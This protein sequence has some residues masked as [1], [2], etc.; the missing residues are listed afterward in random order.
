M[1]EPI[2]LS[3]M[4]EKTLKK[5]IE[6][7]K[8]NFRAFRDVVSKILDDVKRNGDRAL[9]KYTRIYDGVKI[10]IRQLK[11]SESEV[12]EAYRKTPKTLIKAIEKASKNLREIHEKQLPKNRILKNSG[13]VYVKQVFKPINSVGLYVPC[14][15][16][17]YPST[18]LMLGIPAKIA[19]VKRLVACTPPTKT[20]K[21]NPAILVAL[22]MVGVD[23]VY[24]V[25]G[26]QA[27][28]ALA[29]GTQTI[30]RVDKIV[31]PGNIYVTTAKMMVYGEVGIDF[32]AGPS[33][34]LVFAD[35]TANPTLVFLDMVSQAEHDNLSVPILV[36]TSEKLALKVKEKILEFLSKK[37]EKKTAKEALRKNSA[38]VLVKDE[39]EAANFINKFAPEHL[40]VFA[41]NPEK[42]ISLIYNAGLISVGKYTPVAVADYAIGVSHVLPTSRTASFHSGLTVYDFLK[43]IYIQQLTKNGLKRLK[44]IVEAFAMV[45]GLNWHAES[46]RRRFVGRLKK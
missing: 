9:I 45:E 29:Y 32:P 38:I 2:R 25:G 37:S 13:G 41:K 46:V 3:E 10:S 35:E 11:V 12:L 26:V 21:V 22:D 1:I 33:E 27:I 8:P 34:I 40:E 44:K 6:R 19:G 31:G 24:R 39:E 17:S 15:K 30:P 20:G 28:G 18:V 14:G 23:E 43:P 42:L 5:I 36:T 7:N 16:A 4:D